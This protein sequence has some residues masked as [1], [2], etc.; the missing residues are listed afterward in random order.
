MTDNKNVIVTGGSGLLGATVVRLLLEEGRVRPVVMDLNPDPQRLSDIQDEIE[1]VRGDVSDPELLN[2]TFSK[3][4]PSAIYHIAAVL[5]DTCENNHQLAVK[6]NVN[7]FINLLEAARRNEVA[8][9][10]FS[11]S[12]TTYGDD[13][14]EGEV[15]TDKTLQRP[16]SFYG[17]TKVFAENVGRYYRKKYGFDYRGIHYPAIVGPGLRGSGV[18][19]YTSAMIEVPAGGEPYTVPISPDIRL[20]L[21]YVEDGARA[22][23]DLGR[24]PKRMI[25]AV[26]YFINGVQNPIPNAGEMVEMV[27]AKIPGARITFEVNPDWDRLLR[28]ASHLVDDSSSIKEW[29]WKPRYDNWNKIIDVYL[30]ALG[31]GT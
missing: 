6:V 17:I 14:E 29:G 12:A 8:Q 27:N 26:N 19:T 2:D 1:Y 9:V 15:L 5:G 7:G 24:A 25:K 11:S 10:L 20:S 23:I 28:S 18:V 13:L 3:F 30:Q 31:Q 21:I 4:R 22:L 16:A